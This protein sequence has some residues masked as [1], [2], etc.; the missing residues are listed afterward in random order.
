[1]R[2]LIVLILVLSSIFVFAQNDPR[3]ISFPNIMGKQTM[4]CDFHLHTVF[5]DGEVWPTV[6]VDEAVAE[7]IDVICIS[8][9]IEYRPHEEVTGDHNRAYEIALKKAEKSDVILIRGAEIT[10]NM[11]PGHF[12]AVFTSD[13]NLLEDNDFKVSLGEA[14]KQGAFIMWN[15]P[16][17]RQENNIPIWYEEHDYIYN[18]GWMHGM[19]I[20]NEKTYYPLAHKWCLEKGITILGGSDLHSPS[21]LYYDFYK[22]EHRTVTLVFAEERTEESVK[23]ALRNGNTAVFSSNLLFGSKEILNSIA[24]KSL[25]MTSIDSAI[26]QKAEKKEVFIRVHYEN[27]SSLNYELKLVKHDTLV[28]EVQTLTAETE[29][30]IMV[31]PACIEKAE[32]PNTY[33]IPVVVKNMLYA[34]DQSIEYKLLFETK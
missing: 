33:Y 30:Y 28:P 7:G 18:Q 12:N 21:G 22:G 8:D 32:K 11:P 15:H 17:W 9:H 6:R 3:I 26:N 5:S 19:E 1:M 31:T 13:N 4:V 10:K 20:V 24:D 34:P 16:G 25:K 14:A 29:D 2:V 27:L 23:N